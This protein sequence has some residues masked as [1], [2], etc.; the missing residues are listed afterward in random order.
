M[1]S[2][3]GA[4]PDVTFLTMSFHRVIHVGVRRRSILARYLESLLTPV[5]KHALEVEKGALILAIRPVTP[6]PVHHVPLWAQHKTVFAERIQRRSDVSTPITLTV[7]AVERFVAICSLAV[8]TH[9]RDLVTKV[10]AD[11][12]KKKLTPVATAGKSRIRFCVAPPKRK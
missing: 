7:G 11:L 9:V 12:A 1:F 6:G 2:E 4:A 5:D 3:C 10:F 8:N